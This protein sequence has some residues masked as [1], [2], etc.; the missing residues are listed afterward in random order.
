MRGRVKRTTAR[1]ATYQ[2]RAILPFAL[3]F[4][5]LI[6]PLGFRGNGLL[7]PSQIVA[8]LGS[9]LILGALVGFFRSNR[10]AAK[11]GASGVYRS[12][13][14]PTSPIVIV[15]VLVAVLGPTSVIL[16]IGMLN[17]FQGGTMP[18]WFS[19]IYAVGFAGIG[20]GITIPLGIMWFERR[21]KCRLW[22]HGTPSLAW[23]ERIEYRLETFGPHPAGA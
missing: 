5:F 12:K 13:I 16:Y 22:I 19:L 2:A 17:I 7:D 23:P 21:S 1:L 14:N 9:G 20:L 11:C 18:G 4:L 8:L 10:I 3:V 15:T 6:S